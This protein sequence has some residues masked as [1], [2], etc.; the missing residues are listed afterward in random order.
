MQTNKPR[1]IK[2]FEKLDTHI[3][4]QIKLVYPNGF[5]E[6][7]ISFT[8]REGKR[9]KAL[10]FEAE[11]K[12]YLIRMTILEAQEIIDQDDDYDDDGTLKDDVKEEYE[13]KYADL[14]YIAENLGEDNEGMDD[15]DQEADH[16]DDDEE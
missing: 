14:D 4:E 2:D 13:D 9:V 12:Y 15:E 5:F 6:H 16:I 10:P 7:L 3:Q 8:N 1:V 11:D